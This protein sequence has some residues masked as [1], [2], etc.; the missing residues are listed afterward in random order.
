MIVTAFVV[1]VSVV[2]WLLP[3]GDST[4]LGLN[5][6]AA[7]VGSPVTLSVTLQVGVLLPLN[8]TVTA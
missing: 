1:I 2:F 5:E 8:W 3:P 7:P 4:G 6:P